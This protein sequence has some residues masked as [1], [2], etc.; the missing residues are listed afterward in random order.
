MT[1]K[2]A[3]FRQRPQI[4][5]AEVEGESKQSNIDLRIPLFD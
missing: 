5:E 2:P 3:T 4:D 1:G